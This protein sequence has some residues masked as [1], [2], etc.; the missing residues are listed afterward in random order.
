MTKLTAAAELKVN[1]WR[2]VKPIIRVQKGA[3]LQMIVQWS[4]VEIEKVVR[5]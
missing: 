1:D 3:G 4:K 5:W 2:A